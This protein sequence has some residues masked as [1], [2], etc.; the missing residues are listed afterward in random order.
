M[1]VTVKFYRGAWWVFINHQGRRKAKRIG[2]REAAR[3]V[4]RA[5]RERLTLGDLDLV[6][7]DDGDQLRAYADRWLE[8]T[9]GSLKA[10]T[11]E[12]YRSTLKRY[13]YPALGTRL[14]SSIRRADCRELVADCRGRGLAVS[15]V[16]GIARSLSVVLA[17]AVEDELLPANPALRL[18]KYLRRGDEPE[19]EPDPFAREE[20][21]LLVAVAAECFPE[22]H[23]W[24]LT[25]LRTGLR[26]GE[27]LGLQWGDIDWRGRFLQLSRSIVRGNQTTPKN[28]QRR[29]VDLSPQL[30]ATL[31]WW[32][33]QQSA[34]WLTRGKARPV[35]VFPSSTGT[36]LDESKVRK[37]FHQVLDKAGLHR[38]GP[39]QMRHTFASLLIQAGVPITYVS[40]Q[41]GHRDSAITL[42]VYAHWL[43]ETGVEKGVD[44]LDDATSR[45]LYATRARAAG[46]R[47]G[48]KSLKENGEPPRNRT[49][50]PQIK[51]LL[52]CQLS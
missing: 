50:N 51:S 22:W 5:I 9:A 45:N 1:G 20:T 48:S 7:P 13:V 17:S 16:R 24:V 38:R 25:G 42:R 47:Y 29:R 30:R 26:A 11:V 2:D 3:C 8:S 46:E 27:L 19:A 32:R 44:R 49:G 33:A 12:F 28:H 23:A 40:R 36:P 10:S 39:H 31:R 18:G 52:L 34:A 37:A 4:A 14:V 41:L 15:T 6:S 35:W 21:E 43:P